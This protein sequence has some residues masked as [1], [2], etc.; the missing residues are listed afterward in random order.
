MQCLCATELWARKPRIVSHLF[1]ILFAF[2][3]YKFVVRW[4]QQRGSLVSFAVCDLAFLVVALL[5]CVVRTAKTIAK[6]AKQPATIIFVCTEWVKNCF[7]F[8]SC[9][10]QV[11][12]IFSESVLK[13]KNLCASYRFSVR[14]HAEPSAILDTHRSIF[15]KRFPLRYARW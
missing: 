6:T 8:L 14:F 5:G 3:R 13:P 12:S 9:C 10:N 4:D 1:R 2:I 15:L 11:H 7:K